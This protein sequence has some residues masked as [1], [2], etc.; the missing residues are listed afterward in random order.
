MG[1]GVPIE[2]WLRGP[3]D[4]ICERLFSRERLDRFG[5]LSSDELSN[6]GFRRW[7]A[8]DPILVWHIFALAA[9]CEANL[10][11]G[12]DALRELLRTS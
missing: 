5:V 11:D 6:G 1:F 8:T 9:W 3:F 12:P 4:P 2:K 10:G 7:R